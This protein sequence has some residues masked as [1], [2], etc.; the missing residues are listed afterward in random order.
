MS[1]NFSAAQQPIA[2]FY[3][4]DQGKV[5]RQERDT[6]GDGKMDRWTHYD[7]EGRMERAEHDVN[8]DGK[9]D[10]FVF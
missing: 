1:G 6:N 4:D 9:P 2:S 7:A 5:V 8:L 10:V 3:Y